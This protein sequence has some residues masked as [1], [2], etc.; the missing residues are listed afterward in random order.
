MPHSQ[1]GG[2]HCSELEQEVQRLNKI[3]KALMGRVERSTDL[4]GGAFSLFQAATVLEDRVQERTEALQEALRSLETSNQELKSAKESADLANAAK[5]EFLANMSHELRTPLHG[6]L[7][8]ANIGID[9]HST[10]T[11]EKLVTYFERIR[12]SGGTLLTLLNDLLD[13]AKL[14]AGKTVFDCEPVDLALV[15]ESVVEEFS[16]RLAEKELVLETARPEVEAIAFA[17]PNR[18]KQ[19]V[20]N[21]LSNAVRFSPVAGRINCIVSRRDE[22]VRVSVQDNGPG[23]RPDELELVFRKFVQSSTTKTGAGGTGLGLAIC[24][25]IVDAHGGTIRA[26]NNSAGGAIFSFELPLSGA[27][28]LDSAPTLIRDDVAD[29]SIGQHRQN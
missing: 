26:E 29:T 4:T 13:L 8:F 1:A 16:S 17:D 7:S 11:R 12:R 14:E 10:A 9:K 21:L 27:F 18:I 15:T 2:C 28:G 23:I 3:N 19:V 6:I 22:T 24:R 5:S 25:E 20:R